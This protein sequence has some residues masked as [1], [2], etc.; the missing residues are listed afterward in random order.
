MN[1]ALTELTWPQLKG[2]YEIYA[3]GR[4]RSRLLSNSFIRQLKEKR[5]LL[6]FKTGNQQILEKTSSYDAFFQTHLLE[7]Y[8]RYKTFLEETAIAHDGK[9]PYTFYDLDTLIYIRQHKDIFLQALST[10]RAFSAQAF[11]GSKYLEENISVSKAVLKLFEL[12][13]FPRQD[14][15]IQQWRLVIDSADPLCIILCENLDALKRPDVARQLRVELW[16]V[17]GN[18]IRILDFLGDHQLKYPVYYMCDW[19]LAGMQIFE[20]VRSIMA[21]KGTAIQLLE[22]YDLSYSRPVKSGYHNS[23]WRSDLV[24]SGLNPDYFSASATKL[25]RQLIQSSHWIEEETQELKLLLQF[26]QV[27][28]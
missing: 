6:K 27:L 17:G 14:P 24:L 16:Y 10:E 19:D 1:L 5:R 12:E 2:L 18:N 3:T 21:Q 4:T 7:S 26:N 23:E 20:R 8:E 11:K 13:A 28:E 22:P 25:I 9:R 15:K